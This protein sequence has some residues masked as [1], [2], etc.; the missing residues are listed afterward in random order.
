ML[1]LTRKRYLLWRPAI[2]TTQHLFVDKEPHDLPQKCVV[3]L[4]MGDDV[5]L[6]EDDTGVEDVEGGIVEGAGKDDVFQKLEAVGVVDFALYANIS[7]WNGLVKVG[8][9]V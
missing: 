2:G 7:D 4:N 6:V 8:C 5:D 9:L 1:R 3:L